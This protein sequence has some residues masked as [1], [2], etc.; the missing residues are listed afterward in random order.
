MSLA[1]AFPE[2]F[3][4]Y[5]FGDIISEN[6]ASPSDPNDPFQDTAA[7]GFRLLGSPENWIITLF[8]K[9]L[10]HDLYEELANILASQFASRFSLK[11]NNPMM[12]SPPKEISLP[13]LKKWMETHPPLASKTYWHLWHGNAYPLRMFVFNIEGDSSCSML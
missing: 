10:D 13:L 1:E 5:H 7:L 2:G 12:I 3:Q 8:N 11:R 6:E 4:F 9:N